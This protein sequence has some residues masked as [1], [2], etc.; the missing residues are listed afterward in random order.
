[1]TAVLERGM[2][3]D[4]E[5]DVSSALRDARFSIPPERPTF[6]PRERLLDAL[7][8]R[9][10]S[11]RAPITV[12]AAPIS[13]G[14][15]TAVAA[16][17]R[18]L[19]EGSTAW[20]RLDASDNDPYA[21]G[22]SILHAVLGAVRL[23][24]VDRLS[25]ILAQSRD[26]L[27]QAMQLAGAGRDLLL[28][29]DCVEEL[30]ANAA[31]ATLARLAYHLPGSVSVV[32]LAHH[33]PD[34]PKRLC[35]SAEVRELRAADLA[36]TPEEAH[37]LLARNG[38]ALPEPDVR[39]L[40]EWTKGSAAALHLAV[41]AIREG[42]DPERLLFEA[43]Q[44]ERALHDALLDEMLDRLD[45]D[46][47]RFLLRV[48][49]TNV[50]NVSLAAALCD[51]TL[52]EA[53][54]AMKVVVEQ[55]VFFEPVEAHGGWYR[56]HSLFA[57]LLR[58]ALN[59]EAPDEIVS[60][61]RRAA[62]WFDRHSCSEHAFRC[63]VAGRDWDLVVELVTDRWIEATLDGTRC[64][65]GEVPELPDDLAARSAVH[66][67]AA[68]ILDVERNRPD[69]ARLRLG[70][71][72]E[73]FPDLSVR[74]QLVRDLLA[75]QLACSEGAPDAIEAAADALA[76][77]SVR[78]DTP[79]D[80]AE[81]VSAL[82]LQGDAW[83]RLAAGDV[84]RAAGLFQESIAVSIG[85]DSSDASATAALALTA[86][87]AGSV[88][89]AS[90][91]N[92]ELDEGWTPARSGD[93]TAVRAL[94]SAICAYHEDRLPAAQQ[95][96][97]DAR[98]HLRSYAPATA[99]LHAVRARIAASVGDDEGAERLLR[100]AA[101]AAG[102][103]LLAGLCD[104]LD[105]H[106]ARGDVE[107]SGARDG[108]RSH[109]YT[110]VMANV[111]LAVDDYATARVDEAWAALERALAIAARNGY[112]RMFV[113][114][115]LPVRPLLESY[116]GHARPFRALALQLL[117]RMGTGDATGDGALVEKL[118]E[119]ELTVLRYLPTMLSNREIASEM[120][121]SVNT[122]KTHLKS[123]YRKLDVARR[124]DAVQRARALS[125]I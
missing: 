59:H 7:I 72:V 5:R 34:L 110:I 60:I 14:K 47:R 58:A 91:I 113:D 82:A 112:R 44:A 15:T 67:F 66:G 88:H 9:D 79:L 125:L 114:S 23:G 109:P 17:A 56:Q 48:S 49:I 32:L 41:A 61:H 31:G 4:C 42:A 11:P 106:R 12:L 93:V 108:A 100:R 35:S 86:A 97:A 39:V 74:L 117:D 98:A 43:H 78:P 50:L 94:T 103:G 29:L 26:P 10:R 104:A 53:A 83:A 92:D 75:L 68:C 107:A 77:W 116:V 95:A 40:T 70:G 73:S 111:R 96:I 54:D 28:V 21:F 65:L 105:L 69:A 8:G 84:Q 18:A 124:R 76:V 80:A 20:C 120:F 3:V 46:V 27:D 16:A 64:D 38:V 122:V 57:D 63:A 24:D 90:A 30:H 51:S 71:M 19:P 36:F 89:L 25:V 55:D 102:P 119:R 123:I 99:V 13:T 52:A 45:V 2:L 85:G 22:Q 118:T 6:L 33:D 81:K 37:A 115:G 101:T 1:M 87:L 62:R 121:F